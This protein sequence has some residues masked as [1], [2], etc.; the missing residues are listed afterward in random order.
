MSNPLHTPEVLAIVADIRAAI[1][2]VG[3]PVNEQLFSFWVPNEGLLSFHIVAD[4]LNTK[5]VNERLA[6]F[7][8]VQKSVIR[9]SGADEW[10]I[11]ELVVSRYLRLKAL[12]G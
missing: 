12:E 3:Q 7:V 1:T 11:D 6:R 2:E 10:V 9:G 8:K 4:A 5:A